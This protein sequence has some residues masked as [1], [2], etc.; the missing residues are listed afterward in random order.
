[1]RSALAPILAFLA[2]SGIVLA[3]V[4]APR[5]R[6][7]ELSQQATFLDH[8][9]PGTSG[10]PISTG[11]AQ[12][13]ATSAAGSEFGEL[14]ILRR[15]AHAEPFRLSLDTQGYFTDNVALT[16]DHRQE[17]W[18][19]RTG[20]VISYTNRVYENWFADVTLQYHRFRYDEFGVLDFDLTRVEATVLRQVPSLANSFLYL[21]FAYERITEA[22]FGSSLF[23]D[24]SLEC[25]VQKTWKI[26]RGQQIFGALSSDFSLDAHPEFAGR[27]EYAATLG[28]SV[29]L[30]SRVDAA[31]SYRSSWYQYTHAD[32]DD[33]TQLLAVGATWELTTWLRLGANL[34]YTHNT[35]SVAAT[36]YRSLVPGAT[37]AVQTVF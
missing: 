5:T 37:V 26:A 11:V 29:R 36:S 12:D 31:L 6:V 33:W 2:G 14:D 17:D 3:Q 10:H 23:N 13:S 35:S 28:Y 7:Q 4:P 19:L 25:G 30:T 24:F 16:P 21:R 8:Q 18:Y 15:R 20:A 34:T 1:M 22:D 27:H 9:Q 32:R